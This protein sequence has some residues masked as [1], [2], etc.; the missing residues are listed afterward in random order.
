ML[1]SLDST[2]VVIGAGLLVGLKHAMEADHV[3]AVSTIVSERKSLLSSSLIGGLWGLGHT[4]SLLVAGLA[5]LLLQFQIS[6]RMEMALEFGVGLML[7]LLGVNALRK[8]AKGGK[9][10]IHTHQHGEHL[11]VH[12]HIHSVAP[13]S[14]PH[15]HH[16]MK[17][18]ARPVI[19]GMIHGLAGSGALMLLILTSIESKLLGLFYIAV[20]G[21]GSIGGMVL[22]SALIGLPVHLTANRFARANWTVRLLAGM[23]SLGYGL[24]MAYEI[25]FVEG[26][27]G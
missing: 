7:I 3:A 15:T 4:V 27:F 26:L 18:S 16:G 8:L 9:L 11:H 24:F 6:K 5:V 21:V 23:F 13:E 1:E 14:D 20:F 12:P 17:L 25:G 22:M 10:H 19:I 2:V